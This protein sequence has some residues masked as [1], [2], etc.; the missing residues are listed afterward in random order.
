MTRPPPELPPAGAPKVTRRALNRGLALLPLAL[1]GC[2]AERAASTAGGPWHHTADGFRNPPGSPERGGDFGDWSSFFLRRF[3]ERDEVALP[4]GHLLPEAEALDGVVNRRSDGDRLTW[5]GHASFLLRLDGR[6]ILTDP[7]LSAHASPLPPLG[8]KRFAPPGLPAQR[9]PRIDLL[10]LSHN[11]YDHLD[12]PTVEALA[13]KDRVEV[14]VPLGLSRYFR[15]RGYLKVHEL[16]WYHE[17]TLLGLKITALPAIHFSK[18]TPFDRNRT[19]WTG[20]AIQGRSKRIYFA[21]DTAYGP[22]FREVSRRVAPFDLALLPIGAYEPRLLMRGSH[23]TPEESLQIARE[24]GARRVVAMH[25]GTIRLTD[26]PPFEPPERFRAAAP[27]AGYGPDDA[28]LL[29]I[30]E[31]RAV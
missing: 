13:G 25:W 16:D 29:R 23:T 22:V 31:T 27:A 21:G 2:A 18:R 15:E 11:H 20:Y 3:A 4:A 12:L 9:L 8:P 19:L 7:Y 28:W 17:R 5:L 1:A 10:L 30:G 26:E 14:V 6:T 24:L